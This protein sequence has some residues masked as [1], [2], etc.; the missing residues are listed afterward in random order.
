MA[1]TLG[2]SLP[3]ASNLRSVRRSRPMFSPRALF[4]IAFIGLAGAIV[5]GGYFLAPDEESAPA[6]PARA[7]KATTK[8]AP[9]AALP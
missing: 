6:I 7:P 1:D 3:I 9:Q 8:P 2:G 5:V 4:W